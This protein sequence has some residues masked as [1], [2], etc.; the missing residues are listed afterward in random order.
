[1]CM[2]PV[3]EALMVPLLFSLEDAASG[4]DPSDHRTV[5]SLLQS[6]LMSF[7]PEE[8]AEFLGQVHM[9]L[10]LCLMEL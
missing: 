10:L 8:T 9:C 6:V 1:M 3:P 7:G 4:S 2:F 5:S